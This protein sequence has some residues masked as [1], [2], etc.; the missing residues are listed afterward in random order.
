MYTSNSPAHL[1][2]QKTTQTVT[3]SQFPSNWANNLLISNCKHWFQ[4]TVWYS[5]PKVWYELCSLQQVTAKSKEPI[6]DSYFQ[7]P[8]WRWLQ[9]CALPY[10]LVSGQETYCRFLGYQ[11]LR[12]FWRKSRFNTF[13]F[14]PSLTRCSPLNLCLCLDQPMSKNQYVRVRDHYKKKKNDRA[15]KVWHKTSNFKFHYY[16]REL[17]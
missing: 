17:D 15:T 10:T 2:Q 3:A 5:N 1:S 6:P 16:H 13:H 9:G 14:S 12:E 7:W 8:L 4:L 11:V